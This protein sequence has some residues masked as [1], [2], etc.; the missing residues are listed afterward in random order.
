MTMMSLS[1][2]VI[3]IFFVAHDEASRIPGAPPSPQWD[4]HFPG[5]SVGFASTQIPV[6]QGVMV[7]VLRLV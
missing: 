7:C 4:S 6:W 5:A 1:K 2:P 3:P